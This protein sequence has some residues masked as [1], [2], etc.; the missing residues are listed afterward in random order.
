MARIGQSRITDNV[1]DL[2]IAQ[3]KKLPAQ[4]VEVLRLAACLGDRFDLATLAAIH[5]AGRAKTYRQLFPALQQ[6][7]VLPTS[8]L[9]LLDAAQPDAPLVH[10]HFKFAHDRFQQA[11][12]GLIEDA[13][14]P[15]L[16]L[17]IG[18]LLR[19]AS[20]H[21][22]RIFELVD[23]LNQGRELLTDPAERIE[24]AGLNLEAARKAKGSAAY[25]VALHYLQ[26]ALQMF[27]GDW[28]RQYA[29]T[30]A[31]HK[32]SAEVEYLNGHYERSEWLINQ[33]WEYGAQLDR[34]EA[35]AQLVT[36]RTMLGKN[37][38]AINAAAKALNL[39]GVNFPSYA[40]LPQALDVELKEIERGLKR[41][42]IASLIDLPEMQEP[43]I[44]AVMK[45]L[46]TMHTTAYFA[47]RYDLYSWALARMTKLSM[48]YGN[49]PESA[50]GYA[51]F[52]NTISSKLGQYQAGYEFGMLGLRLAEK[53][54][55]QSLKCKACLIL[56]MFLNHWIRP[57]AEA[58]FFDEEG[59]C[60]GVESGEFQFVGYILFYGR[61]LGRLHRGEN[62]GQLLPDLAKYLAF[63]TKVKHH[64]SSDNLQGAML[65]LTPLTTDP[66][67]PP[68]FDEEQP[69]LA[70]CAANHSLLLSDLQ[71][72]H[73]VFAWRNGRRLCL[74]R[75]GAAG[76]RLRQGRADRGAAQFLLLADPGG[77]L[78]RL[79]G[80]ARGTAA[81]G[82][83]SASAAIV[84]RALPG[85]LPAP[86]SADPGRNGALDRA[87][88]GRDG[89]L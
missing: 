63:T 85:Q 29:L 73:P 62:L 7:M 23:H 5:Q 18:R 37:E 58:E 8:E 22:E 30:L 20:D 56:S 32:E 27:G 39:L 66:A 87:G 21:A 36:Q 13:L 47:N 57:I 60:A 72:L 14:K 70:N 11:A 69:Y 79:P 26:G 19:A 52:G 44:I 53:Y 31:L 64:L 1:A 9:E 71:G 68:R 49:I 88:P 15:R 61:T 67:E 4:S 80:P 24:L 78:P 6:G 81:T 42:S 83:Q 46:M 17:R 16:H 59:L 41:R 3:L 54:N 89:L 43:N 40:S 35:Y 55:H 76:A 48:Q 10:Q 65:A 51:S 2:M 12:Y 33:I 86:V 45:V 74:H 75:R 25:G 50:K 77:R 38:E 82:R 34:A 84:G 28:E